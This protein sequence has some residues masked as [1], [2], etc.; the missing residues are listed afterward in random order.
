MSPF[1]H[2]DR[3]TLT[4]FYYERREARMYVPSSNYLISR[5]PCAICI[6]YYAIVEGAFA[7][8]D[9]MLGVFRQ[10]SWSQT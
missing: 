9:K 4:R 5:T 10:Y 2:D 6:L 7:L 1:R 8:R 3:H